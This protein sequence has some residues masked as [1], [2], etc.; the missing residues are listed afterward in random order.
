MKKAIGFGV[1]ALI[2]SFTTVVAVYP[3][4]AQTTVASSAD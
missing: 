3:V 4:S 1:I 2:L